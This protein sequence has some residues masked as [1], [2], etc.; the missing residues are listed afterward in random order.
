[1]EP[2]GRAGW[3]CGWASGRSRRCARRTPTGSRGARQRLPRGGGCLAPA[4]WRPRTL[5][6]RWPRP[7]PSPLGLSRREALWAARALVPKGAELPLF[8]GDLDG[9]G[10]VEPPC[11]P[12]DD[13]GRG[14]GGGLRRHAA[15][16]RAHPV[17]LIRHRLSP[18]IDP[19]W[20]LTP[21]ST[22]RARLDRPPATRLCK[23]AARAQ[24][25]NFARRWPT[26]FITRTSSSLIPASDRAWPACRIMWSRP[27]G[28]PEASSL[29]A[30]FGGQIMS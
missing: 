29:W 28:Q 8:S 11:L 24:S 2:D 26:T 16:A 27:D 1:M 17:A 13:R 10:I 25:P 5:T 3:R 21:P 12:A 30:D 4:G 22:A 15:D 14:G 6:D 9:E 20:L 19:R 23:D 18:G 7:M